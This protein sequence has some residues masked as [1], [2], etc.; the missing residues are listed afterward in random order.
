[1]GENNGQRDHCEGKD[2]HGVRADHCAEGLF[3]FR[4]LTGLFGLS[5]MGRNKSMPLFF[6]QKASAMQKSLLEPEMQCQSY[7]FHTC[8]CMCK[9]ICV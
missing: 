8:T 1:M 3:L 5:T 6:C 7:P 9:C 2:H 4:W